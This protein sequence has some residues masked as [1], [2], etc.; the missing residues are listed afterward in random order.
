ML[1][2]ILGTERQMVRSRRRLS[3]KIEQG[4]LT[5]KRMGTIVLK[6]IQGFGNEGGIICSNPLRPMEKSSNSSLDAVLS[7]DVRRKNLMIMCTM[8]IHVLEVCQQE[9]LWIRYISSL[10]GR[11]TGFTVLQS[12]I[13]MVPEGSQLPQH[14]VVRVNLQASSSWAKPDLVEGQASC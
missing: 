2:P 10:I 4:C 1:C 11:K 9:S 6:Y 12:W 14:G 13:F 7:L 3:I 8:A 5:E